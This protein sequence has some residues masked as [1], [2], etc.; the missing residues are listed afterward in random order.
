MRDG[1]A[2]AHRGEG[3]SGPGSHR[4]SSPQDPSQLASCPQREGERWVGRG[5]WNVSEVRR[6]LP[7]WKKR[8]RRCPRALGIPGTWPL[9]IPF[10]IPLVWLHPSLPCPQPAFPPSPFLS[11]PYFATAWA[12]ASKARSSPVAGRGEYRPQADLSQPLSPLCDGMSAVLSLGG[13]CG[14][15]AGDP[16]E[17]LNCTRAGKGAMPFLSWLQ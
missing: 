15:S 5:L 6:V 11:T 4:R 2:E 7:R 10:P 9:R 16:V 3:P 1:K 8:P 13:W 17:S 12:S 14:G